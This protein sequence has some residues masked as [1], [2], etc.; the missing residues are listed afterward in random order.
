MATT[1]ISWTASDSSTHPRFKAYVELATDAAQRWL[2]P[3]NE[4]NQYALATAGTLW[5]PEEGVVFFSG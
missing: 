2:P 1:S 3:E 4:V 5:T